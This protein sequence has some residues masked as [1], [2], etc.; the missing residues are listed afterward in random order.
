MVVRGVRRSWLTA[1]RMASR[2][3][4]ARDTAAACAGL[5]PQAPAL[6]GDHEVRGEGAD[7]PA[8]IGGEPVT[9]HEQAGLAHL[10]GVGGLVGVRRR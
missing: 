1:A 5:G 3:S 6:Q 4:P 2:T 9:T 8:V 7:D 10:E